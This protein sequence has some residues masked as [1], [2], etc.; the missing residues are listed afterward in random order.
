MPEARIPLVNAALMLATAPKSNSAYEAMSVA[1]ADLEA[2]LGKNIPTH[3]QS[4]L[5][6]GY[7]YPHDFKNHYV[8]QTYL[9]EDLVGK[10]YY[11]FGENKTEQAAKAYYEMM[12]SGR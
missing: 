4:P 7:R 10:Q 5:F 12:R 2:G 1:N 11:V 6:R 3:L 8:E 9:P